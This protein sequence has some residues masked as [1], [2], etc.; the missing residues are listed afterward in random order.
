MYENQTYEAILE[1]MLNR[2]PDKFDKREGSLIFDTH[3]P[4]A[5]ELQI[6][7]LE[8]E[9]LISE[10]YG[11]TA[12]REF[13]IL[14][15]RDRGLTPNAATNAVLQGKFTPSTVDVTGKRFNISNINYVVTEKIQDGYYKVRCETA[16]A[17]GNQYLGQMIPIEY[18]EGLETA[19]LTEVLIPGN[20]EEDTESLRSRYFASF[21]EFQFGGNRADYAAKVK[22]IDGVGGLKITRVWNGDINPAAMIP[23]EAVKDWFESTVGS[24]SEEVSAWLTSVYT[25][26]AGK[27]LTVG[28]TVLITIVDSDDYGEASK[29]LI[30]SIQTAVDPVQNAGEGFGIAPI[31]HLVTIRSASPVTIQITTKIV[32]AEGSTWANRKDAIQETVSEYLLELRKVW[33]DNTYTVV[34]ISQIESRLLSVEGV[35][36]ITETKINGRT[37]NLTLGEY[38]IPVLGGVSM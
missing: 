28:G 14:L 22:A 36:D 25:A 4:T 38:E 8:L 35:V 30:D 29:T 16:G 27:K 21:D 34:R 1:R 7:Y 26:A 15:C 3:S 10:S 12:S 13:L 9:T 23:N 17:T 24:L 19:E 18:I 5:I 31:G 2:V 11:D 6:L 37:D 33:V 32:F 20:D